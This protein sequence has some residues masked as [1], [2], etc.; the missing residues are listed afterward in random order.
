M[1][2]IIT[3]TIF[4]SLFFTT[5]SYGQHISP[6]MQFTAPVEATDS[7]S[8][9]LRYS[10]L[11]YFRD[12]EYT[13]D[14]QTGYTVFGTWHSPRLSIQPNKWLLMEAGALLQKE[15]GDKKLDRALPLFSLQIKQKNFRILFG[16]LESNQSHK[17]VEPLMSFEKLTQR[18]IEEGFQV[19]FSNKRLLADLW[20]DWEFRQKE[21]DTLP[22]EL[23]IGMNLSYLLTHPDKPWRISIPVQVLA[24]HKGGQL[25]INGAP[26]ETVL[27]LSGGI[28][29][30]WNNPNSARWLQHAKFDIHF[31]DYN[32]FHN[33]N[34]YAYNTGSGFLANAYLRSKSSLA[35]LATYW[36]G[37]N[38]VA[39]KGGKLYQSI[40]SI[41][42]R[43]YKEPERQLLFLNLIFEK[44]IFPG[45]FADCRYSP[46]IDL[47]N[48]FTE[49]SFLILLSY[50]GNF[51]IGRLKK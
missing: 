49:Q 5:A 29:A 34:A 27:N 12:Y 1:K 45:F 43:D 15:F 17:L 46:Y 36:K 16:A 8:L 23:T 42:G 22:E 6:A 7:N 9:S 31:L 14:I 37:E 21:R 10:N 30:E 51:R 19:K 32:L 33:E 50:R 24:P 28:A 2:K 26:V 35:F 38:F 20:L 13:H 41:P 18:P 39:P 3:H 25:D 11:F 44:E 40:S 48:S 4:L 47:G